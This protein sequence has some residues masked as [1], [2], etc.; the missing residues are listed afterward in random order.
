MRRN[1]L[2]MLGALFLFVA[3]TVAQQRNTDIDEIGKRD[4]N[5]GRPVVGNLG[6]E[7]IMGREWADEI[8]RRGTKLLDE[9]VVSEYANRIGQNIA[10]KS[11]AKG[12]FTTKVV[13][14]TAINALALPGD[15]LYINAGLIL[16]AD[17]ESQLAG[18]M[19]HMMAHVAARHA[20]EL[21]A[22][23]GI[24]LGPQ[25][26]SILTSPKSA[27][28]LPP[29]FYTFMRQSEEEA[30]LLGVQ[31]LY[32]AGYDPTAMVS[33]FQKLT[34]NEIA[35][36]VSELFDTPLQTERRVTNTNE[37]I[38]RYLPTRPQNTVTTSEFQNVKA[39]VITLTQ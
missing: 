2:R 4:I 10:I 21:E 31:Y 32:K 15:F 19:A 34:V 13:D 3:S 12:L 37:Y 8:E 24:G 28:T 30:D 35:G 25:K 36:R 9:P 6:R 33:M 16:A 14:S 17:N 1:L 23:N 27:R 18:I 20:S 29:Q 38:N 39:L 5:R 11:D 26:P 7:M 22:R